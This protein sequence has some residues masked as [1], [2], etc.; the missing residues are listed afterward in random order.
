[1]N[2]NEL[3]PRKLGSFHFASLEHSRDAFPTMVLNFRAINIQFYTENR[4]HFHTKRTRANILSEKA[5]FEFPTK[6]SMVLNASNVKA[7]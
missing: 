6:M 5:L 4:R 7:E 1:M 3:Q 2:P